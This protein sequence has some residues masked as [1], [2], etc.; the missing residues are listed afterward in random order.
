MVKNLLLAC[1]LF[2]I[3]WYFMILLGDWFFILSLIVI[4][5]LMGSKIKPKFGRKNTQDK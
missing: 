3:A 2:L 5:V 1:G 4:I